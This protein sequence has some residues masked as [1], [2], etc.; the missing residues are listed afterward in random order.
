[1]CIE[2]VVYYIKSRLIMTTDKKLLLALDQI[3]QIRDG[4]AGIAE[5]QSF[6]YDMKMYF[7]LKQIISLCPDKAKVYFNEWDLYIKLRNREDFISP[8]DS[9]NMFLYNHMFKI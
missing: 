1:M 6:C 9:E 8:H 2:Q 3:P 5:M 7:K 4:K